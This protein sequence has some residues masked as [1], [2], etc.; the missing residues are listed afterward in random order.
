[1]EENKQN[2]A[3]AEVLP[4]PVVAPPLGGFTFALTEEEK[5]RVENVSLRMERNA[6]MTERLKADIVV[7]EEETK[8]IMQEAQKIRTQ[9]SARL[10]VDANKMKI[11]RDGTVVVEG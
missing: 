5:L 11:R 3:A 7:L 4:V 1:M 2:E 8:G 9:I 10:Q 6:L